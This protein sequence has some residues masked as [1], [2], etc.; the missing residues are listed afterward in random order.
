MSPL[1][2][3]EYE[4]VWLLLKKKY[5]LRLE[6]VQRIATKMVPD[7]E[8]LEYEERL[9]E[10]QLTTLN[11]RWERGD[12]ITIHVYKLKNNNLKVTENI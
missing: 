4:V 3:T 8:D 12:L 6:R 2:D 11:E 1:Q 7:F 5:V 9:K 10:M